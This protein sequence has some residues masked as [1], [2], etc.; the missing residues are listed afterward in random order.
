MKRQRFSATFG[1][2]VRQHRNSLGLSQESLAEKAELSP[3]YVG[4]LERNV[5]SPTV[6]AAEKIAR[7]LDTTLAALI[8]EAEQEWRLSLKIRPKTHQSRRPKSG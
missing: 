6:D 1:N 7:A 8:G 3:V 5:R 4:F 2:V